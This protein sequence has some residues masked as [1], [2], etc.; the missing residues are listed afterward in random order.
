MIPNRSV[1]TGYDSFCVSASLTAMAVEAGGQ[2]NFK[3]VQ[4]IP[5]LGE[6]SYS[7]HELHTAPRKGLAKSGERMKKKEKDV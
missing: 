4:A 3:S 7:K 5:E 2:K 1:L 6:K